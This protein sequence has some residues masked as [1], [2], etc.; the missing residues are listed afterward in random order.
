[1]ISAVLTALK[2]VKFVSLSQLGELRAWRGEE[3]CPG[4]IVRDSVG[5]WVWSPGILTPLP[6]SFL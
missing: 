3:A 2:E 1:M 4:H 6:G 5:K